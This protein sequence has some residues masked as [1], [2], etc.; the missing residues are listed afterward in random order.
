MKGFAWKKTK[1]KM[2]SLFIQ[3]GGRPKMADKIVSRYHDD[4][5]TNNLF[6]YLHVSMLFL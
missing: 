3:Y 2:M 4:I 6:M 5:P 1:K